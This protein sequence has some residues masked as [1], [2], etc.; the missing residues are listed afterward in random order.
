MPEE[1]TRDEIDELLASQAVGRLGLVE[2]DVP[3]VVPI[4]YAYRD[5]CIY[6]HSAQGRKLRALRSQPEV[7]FEVDEVETVDRWRSAIAWGRF[8]QLVGEEA[9]RGLDI[10]IERFRP[11]LPPATTETHPDAEVGL[12]R[13]LDIPRLPGAEADLGRTS[14]AAVVFRIRLHTLSGRS[15]GAQEEVLP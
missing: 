15:E 13:T 5:G 2:G 10:L 11:L 12:T 7:C 3:Y 9:K 4:S 14:S 6:G 1:M 8:E